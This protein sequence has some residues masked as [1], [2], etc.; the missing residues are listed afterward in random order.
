MPS[1]EQEK[2]MLNYIVELQRGR[3]SPPTNNHLNPDLLS[4]LIDR[5]EVVKLNEEVVLT[6]SVYE[7]MLTTTVTYM[8]AQ[9]SV[10]VG[11]ARDLFAT[12]RKYVLAFL[13]HL[14]K[15]QV[16]RRSGEGRVLIRTTD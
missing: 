13:E 16:T 8:R 14:D 2:D 11:E 1:P 12:S 10:T 6:A 15:L 7:E 4:L 5:G 3:F 9:G